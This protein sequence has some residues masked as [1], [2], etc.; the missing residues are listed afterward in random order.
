MDVERSPAET[1][2]FSS[3]YTTLDLDACTVTASESEEGQWAERSCPGYKGIRLFVD[4][5]DGRFDIDAGRR[6]QGF[7]SLL[8]FNNP[9]TTIEWRLKDGKPFAVIYRIS[10]ATEEAR[11]RTA[12]FVERIGTD[13]RLGCT[14][15]QVAGDE[16]NPNRKARELADTTAMDFACETDEP[17]L[18][19]NAR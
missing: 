12:L 15:A 17:H 4:D 3:A 1:G 6:N 19:G 9:P 18:V 8:A 10:D 11:G 2:G 16:P 7:E 5:G 13:D 14:V